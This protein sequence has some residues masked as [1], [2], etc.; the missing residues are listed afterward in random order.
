MPDDRYFTARPVLVIDV[1]RPYIG[2]GTRS[3]LVVHRDLFEP[4]RGRVRC[5]ACG[6]RGCDVDGPRAWSRHCIEGHPWRC[7][8]VMCDRPFSTLQALSTHMRHAEAGHHITE[9]P[10]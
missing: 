4:S 6:R 1:P 9:V 5:M 10:A 8:D 7:P 2:P 3:L